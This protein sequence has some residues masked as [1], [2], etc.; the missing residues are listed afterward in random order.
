MLFQLSAWE[1]HAPSVRFHGLLFLLE[2]CMEIIEQE[3]PLIS[4]GF[5]Q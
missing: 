1:L 3:V 4:Y 5:V 2:H